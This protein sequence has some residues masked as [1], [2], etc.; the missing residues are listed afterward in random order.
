MRLSVT[1]DLIVRLCR[2]PA[3]LDDFL[4]MYLESSL[5]ILYPLLNFY[6]HSNRDL[7]FE[8][9]LAKRRLPSNGGAVVVRHNS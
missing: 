6:L 3:E 4:D 7:C 8:G 2:R 5:A 1:L 9:L